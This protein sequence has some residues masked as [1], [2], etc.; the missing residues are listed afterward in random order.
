MPTPEQII[1][2][3]ICEWLQL[4]KAFFWVMPNSRVLRHHSFSR[5][6]IS[7]IVGIWKGR[8]LFIEVKAEGGVIGIDQVRFMK[9]ARAADGITIFAT[10]VEDVA[11]V[12]LPKTSA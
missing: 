3:Q 12:L 10:S 2:T 11:Q 9:D 6:G 5:R 1:K 4:H 8:P 7:D